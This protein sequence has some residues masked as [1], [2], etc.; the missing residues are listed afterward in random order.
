M[1]VCRKSGKIMAKPG[2]NSIRKPAVFF[3]E[4]LPPNEI[5]VARKHGEGCE[6]CRIKIEKFEKILLPLRAAPD[7]DPPRRVVVSAPDRRSRFGWFDWRQVA[8]A[9]A[10]AALI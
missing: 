2:W 7:V 5:T 4:E 3:Y 10:A 6:E 1:R 9:S 8:T